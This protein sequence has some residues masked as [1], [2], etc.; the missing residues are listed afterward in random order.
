MV[1]IFALSILVEVIKGINTGLWT[2]F[3]IFNPFTS[4]VLSTILGFFFYQSIFLLGAVYFKKNNFIKTLLVMIVVV[5]G[6]LFVLN[7]G[8]LIFGLSQNQ[9]FF[10]NIQLGA[11]WLTPLKYI[12]GTVLT[13]F[14]IWLSYVQLKNKQVV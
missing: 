12:I 11:F 5:L 3:N 2:P 8:L 6:T 1:S 10:V 7:I 13:V 4:D 14:F 9:E